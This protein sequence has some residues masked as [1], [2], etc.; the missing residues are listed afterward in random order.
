MKINKNQ[1]LCPSCE[2]TKKAAIVD[3]HENKVG[4]GPCPVCSGRG[5]IEFSKGVFKKSDPGVA[6]VFVGGHSVTGG[7]YHRGRIPW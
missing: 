1:R 2:G 7:Y 6:D 4:E 5:C 3:L